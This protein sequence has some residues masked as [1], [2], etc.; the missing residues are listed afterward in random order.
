ME[1]MYEHAEFANELGSCIVMID[2]IIGYTAIQS[3]AKWC[4]R[5]DMAHGEMWTWQIIPDLVTALLARASRVYRTVERYPSC[6]QA[7]FLFNRQRCAGARGTDNVQGEAQ[8]KLDVIAND[9]FLRTNEWSGYLAGMVSEEL[10]TPY[11]IPPEYPRGRYLLA[12]DPLDG[13]SNIDAKVSVGSIF[14]ALRRPDGVT[15]P[16]VE[17]FLQPG[18]L[19]WC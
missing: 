18:H 10:K 12:F 9:V 2:L 16:Q 15:Q 1:D 8:M 7:D 4:R 19:C 5:N 13:Q 17:D 11:E 3:I 14:S 6:M